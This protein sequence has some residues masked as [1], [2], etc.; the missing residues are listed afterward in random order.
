MGAISCNFPIY[1]FKFPTKI[2]EAQN[3]NLALE[4]PQNG[5]SATNF[6]FLEENFPTG[7]NLGRG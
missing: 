7:L 6:V 2:M 5:F 4:F 3:F 1:S